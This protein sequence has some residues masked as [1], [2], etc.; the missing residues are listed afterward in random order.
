MSPAFFPPP[1]SLPSAVKPQA[2]RVEIVV[3]TFA[4][5]TATALARADVA[6]GA[7][8][9]G[10]LSRCEGRQPYLPGLSNLLGHPL[11]RVHLEMPRA[12][13]VPRTLEQALSYPA[14]YASEGSKV[15]SE[16]T[17]LELTATKRLV[18]RAEQ[19]GV[20]A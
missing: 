14:F 11:D 6:P 15:W 18:I 5:G 9:R 17:A 20:Q 8:M 3:S 12:V 13:D 7:R 19:G 1:S 16:P 2:A 4:D 10:R